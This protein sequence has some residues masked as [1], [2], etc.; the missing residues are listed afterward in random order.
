MLTTDLV[1][2]AMTAAAAA[3]LGA[4]L[5]SSPAPAALGPGA[6]RSGRPAGARR[7]GSVAIIEIDGPLLRYSFGPV[8]NARPL[9]RRPGRPRAGFG[10]GGTR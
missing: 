2:L 4:L 3:E 1:P 8:A 7:D 5:R 9:E 10:R 6:I